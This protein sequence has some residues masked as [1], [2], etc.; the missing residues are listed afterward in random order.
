M[1]L[2]LTIL[3]CAAGLSLTPAQAEPP[4]YCWKAQVRNLD[5]RC[6][7]PARLIDET[8]ETRR[9]PPPFN[10]DLL[11]QGIPNCQVIVCGPL[12][13]G[14]CAVRGACFICSGRTCTCTGSNCPANASTSLLVEEH[15]GNLDQTLRGLRADVT[16]SAKA[17]TKGAIGATKGALG[18]ATR[19]LGL[20]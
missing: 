4:A 11:C 9:Q 15:P 14:K 18:G 12:L 10:P 17:A 8:E 1:R 5:Y 19:S 6:D 13:C 3:V 20:N 2:L 7:S 16:S